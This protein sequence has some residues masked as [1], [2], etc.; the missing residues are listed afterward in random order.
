M[1]NI[2]IYTYSVYN[3]IHRQAP[4]LFWPLRMLRTRTPQ[5]RPWSMALRRIAPSRGMCRPAR[6]T[7]CPIVHRKMDVYL[8]SKMGSS[9]SFLGVFKELRKYRCLGSPW[10]HSSH[11]KWR[12]GPSFASKWSQNVHYP[13]PYGFEK[14]VHLQCI[15][16]S[17]C[18][19]LQW[20]FKAI[21]HVW[22]DPYIM[23]FVVSQLYSHYISKYCIHIFRCLS[24]TFRNSCAFR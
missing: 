14:R 5:V 12:K 15:G 11:P 7:N 21:F 19:P 17:S 10:Y 8:T 23:V 16:L 13:S 22:T 4:A 2:Y 3:A 20:L 24:P 1:D 9:P 18:S 6:F